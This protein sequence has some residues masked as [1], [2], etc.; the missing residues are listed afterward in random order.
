MA[1]GASEQTGAHVESKARELARRLSREH[2]A[3]GD[4]LARRLRRPMRG[5][6]AL[7][8]IERELLGEMSTSLGRA[9]EKVQRVLTELAELGA[10]LDELERRPEPRAQR[11][12]ELLALFRDKRERALRARLELQIQREALGF[13]R[14]A[15]LRELY[16]IPA[17]RRR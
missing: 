1:C 17:P 5:E 16:P 11:V 2:A 7:A 15:V 3:G 10:E 4:A 13:R 8:A 12:D 6:G 14:N 9:E